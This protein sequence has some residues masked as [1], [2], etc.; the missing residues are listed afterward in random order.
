MILAVTLLTQKFSSLSFKVD[1]GGIKEDHIQT[2]EKV[3]AFKKHPL[4]DKVLVAPGSKRGCILLIFYL[5]AKK[6]HRP[7]EV[8]QRGPFYSFDQVI[9]TPFLTGPIRAGNE[10]SM[11]HG[12]EDSPFHIKFELPL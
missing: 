5:F 2:G 6:T 9:P 3:A 11:K 7:I 8:V 1:R 12:E 10:K 4:F